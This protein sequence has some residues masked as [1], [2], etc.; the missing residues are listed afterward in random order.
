MRPANAKWNSI[1]LFG[2]WGDSLCHCH[3]AFG[4]L[5]WSVDL[6]TV[7]PLRGHAKPNRSRY[8]LLEYELISSRGSWSTEARG[9][10]HHIIHLCAC[11][12]VHLLGAPNWFAFVFCESFDREWSQDDALHS[13]ACTQNLKFHQN[14][15]V[16]VSTEQPLIYPFGCTDVRARACTR[17]MHICL[18]KNRN[19]ISWSLLPTV[20]AIFLLCCAR[21]IDSDSVPHC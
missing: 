16:C 6:W 17:H 9:R 10:S 15:C 2:E 4:F 20:F 13:A 8:K 3:H 18:G 11:A 5:M 19:I 1:N 21:A 7:G 12:A 14:R